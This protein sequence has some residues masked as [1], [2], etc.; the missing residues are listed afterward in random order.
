MAAPSYCLF[1]SG[2][3]TGVALVWLG[4]G[5]GLPARLVSSGWLDG[6]L[7]LVA[8]KRRPQLLEAYLPHVRRQTARCPPPPP[9]RYTRP[10]PMGHGPRARGRYRSHSLSALRVQLCELCDSSHGRVSAHIFAAQATSASRRL[11]IPHRQSS[12]CSPTTERRVV[13]RGF[14]ATSQRVPRLRAVQGLTRHEINGG[15]TGN[16][17]CRNTYF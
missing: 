3:R 11:S 17:L 13:S 16:R 1:D 15:S 2:P 6:C 7:P 12:R 5:L 9:I 4:S 14:G 10:N 8:G